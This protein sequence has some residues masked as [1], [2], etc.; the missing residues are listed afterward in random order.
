M[1]KLASLRNNELSA[2]I[3]LEQMKRLNNNIKIRNRNHKLF[4]DYSKGGNTN[5]ITELIYIPNE[6]IDGEYLL[7]L[8]F[9]PI[10]NDA[11]PSRPILFKIDYT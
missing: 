2:V 8:Q 4:F 6:V 10:E 3:G 5:T 9:M 7:N 11:A 1:S